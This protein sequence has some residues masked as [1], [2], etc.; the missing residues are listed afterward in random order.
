MR[1]DNQLAHEMLAQEGL[2]RGQLA[3]T[4]RKEI[5]AMLESQWKKEAR[6]ARMRL[7]IGLVLSVI[8]VE[9]GVVGIHTA[10]P[11]RFLLI[12]IGL[13]GVTV[14]VAAKL[15]WRM[16]QTKLE[17]LREMKEFEL[18]MTEMLKK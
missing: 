13:S 1:N 17:I 16:K 15:G 18:R 11:F 4:E 2:T 10:G 3:D 9:L 6:N 7:W 12:G 5:L 14:A 8:F